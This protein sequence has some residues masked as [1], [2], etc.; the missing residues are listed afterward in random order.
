MKTTR[1][2]AMSSG[3][4]AIGA[5]T[6][7]FRRTLALGM[8]AIPLA[9]AAGA[10][11]QINVLYSFTSAGDGG[12]GGL[13]QSGNTFY[14]VGG[15]GGASNDGTVFSV[16]TDGSNYQVLHTFSGPDGQNPRGGL[17]F[18]S[19][20][21]SPTTLYGMTDGGGTTGNGTVF[22]IP[23]AGGTLTD[24]HNFAGSPD[25]AKP[26]EDSLI[27]SGGTLYGT[28]MFGGSIGGG[29]VFSLPVTGGS[30]TILHSFAGGG[31]LQS[32]LIEVGGTLYG[33]TEGNIIDGGTASG[34]VFS[35]SP[36]GAAFTT[37]A[38]LAGSTLMGP[39]VASATGTTL[40]GMTD[41]GG[42][43]GK[44]SI[45]SLPIGGGAVTTLYSFGANSTDGSQPQGNSLLLSGNTLYG[46]TAQGGT[47]SDGTI[48]AINTDG[49]GY[50][51][52]DSFNGTNGQYPIAVEPILD[53]STIYGMT[54][55]GGANNDG[56]IFSATVPEPATL[57]LLGVGGLGLLLIKRRKTA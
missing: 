54:P 18:G 5:G 19:S 12:Y 31:Y 24:L 11:A 22:S 42:A 37:L 49:T 43:N 39:L 56:V 47:S 1:N 46:M 38:T 9:A 55:L 36:S 29:T 34:T 16:G 15:L 33:T 45:F 35:V 50:H 32:S 41:T 28:T 44:G 23:V 30:T 52:L 13:I 4:S 2:T 27:Q 10:Q 14:G 21:G 51:V 7:K 3:A 26:F 53:G 25:G 57:G 20:T 40:Y 17:I 8:L 6:N 48:F